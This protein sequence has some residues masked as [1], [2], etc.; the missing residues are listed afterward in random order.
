MA[1]NLIP[2]IAKMLG[3]EIGE[4]FKIKGH[5]ELTY[6]FASD[7]LQLTYD[8]NIELSDLAAKVAFVALV[9]GK[10]E[11]VK[12]PWKPKKGEYYFTFVLMGDKWGVGSLHWGGFPN[13][14]ALLAKGWVYRTKEEAKAALPAVAKE[15][16]AEYELPTSDTEAV[17]PWKPKAGEQYYSFGGRFFGDPTVWI[18]IDVIWQGLAYDVAMFDKGWVYK[19]KEEAQAAL[20]K[21]AA[22]IGV[23]YE[24]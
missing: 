24:S 21:V 22:E 18:V 1:K 15:V 13:E 12:L 17:E 4:E 7:R 5:E 9:N 16:G 20:P 11:I 6:R 23:E 14:Y 3:V 8:N 10:D 19:S 2:E